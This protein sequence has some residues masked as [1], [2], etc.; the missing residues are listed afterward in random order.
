MTYVAQF[1]PVPNEEQKRPNFN[2]LLTPGQ[3]GEAIPV[4]GISIMIVSV[5]AIAG[6]LVFVMSKRRR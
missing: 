5:A 3:D 1:T 2:T 4:L 6:C